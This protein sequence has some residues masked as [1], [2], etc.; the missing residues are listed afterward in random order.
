M[1]GV[2]E[3]KSLRFPIHPF[4][5]H[6][7]IGLFVLSFILDIASLSVTNGNLFVRAAYGVMIT[8]IITALLAAIPGFI[9]WLEIRRDHPARRTGLFHMSFNLTVVGLFVVNAIIRHYEI[10]YTAVGLLPL[11]LSIIGLAILGISGYLGGMM[12]YDDGIAVGRYR[13]GTR[14]PAVTLKAEYDSTDGYAT[15][16]EAENLRE[17]ESLRVEAD[18]QVMTVV[19]TEGQLYAVQEF[20]THRYGP[21]SEGSIQNCRL[22]C[23]WHRSQFDLKT[24]Q[25]VQGPAKESLNSFEVVIRDNRVKIKLRD[26]T[27]VRLRRAG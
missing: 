1:S 2:L 23:P 18:G 13:R 15:V 6:F 24:G 20:C 12:I 10:S 21:L 4:L 14:T 5:I 9:D 27:P 22:E 8:G 25:V 3:N 16:P 11:I 19:R 26:V 7:P 17:G